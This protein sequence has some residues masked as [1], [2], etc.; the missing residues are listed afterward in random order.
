MCSTVLMYVFFCGF[1]NHLS[2][3]GFCAHTFFFPLFSSVSS[4]DHALSKSG[5]PTVHIK[6]KKAG[7]RGGSGLDWGWEHRGNKVTILAKF[8]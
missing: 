4:P 2:E 5:N 7:E 8:H 6:E 1:D 3:D